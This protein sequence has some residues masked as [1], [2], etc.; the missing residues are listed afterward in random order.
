MHEFSFGPSSLFATSSGSGPTIIL[1]HGG[2]ATH[3]ACWAYAAPLIARF[4]VVAP[5]LRGSGRSIDPGPLSFDQLADDVAAL[6]RHLGE[7][8]VVVGGS[9][10]GAAVATRVALAHPSLVRALVLLHPAYG[11]AELGLAPAQ[12]AAMAAMDAAARRALVDGMAALFPLLDALPA[13]IRA[14]AR[15]QVAAYDPASVAATTALMASGVQPF[16]RGDDLAAITAPTL[17]VP[18]V[19]PEHPLEVADVFRRHLPRCTTRA[20]SPPDFAAAIAELSDAAP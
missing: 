10:F 3:R 2:L 17:L 16:A 14:R 6:A 8:R 20:I 7:S 4:R 5:D 11:G 1:L 18:G 19:D 15:E 13:D 9:S 12:R